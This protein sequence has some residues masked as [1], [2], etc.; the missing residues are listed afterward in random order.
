MMIIQNHLKRNP[1]RSRGAGRF[2]RERELLLLVRVVR[3]VSREEE[4]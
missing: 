1:L 4:E 2:V 3:V